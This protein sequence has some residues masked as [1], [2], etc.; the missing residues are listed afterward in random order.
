MRKPR[1]FP[2]VLA[3]AGVT[4]GLAVFSA[5]GAQAPL[6]EVDL[7]QA[8]RLALDND[9]ATVGAAAAVSSASADLLEARGLWLPSLTMSSGYSNSS[10]QRVDTATGRLVSE[11]YNAQISASLELFSGGRRIVE[12]RAAAANLKA[13]GADY[14]LQTFQT[15]L[16]TTEIFYDAAAS[17]DLQRLAE[18]RRDR[19]RQQLSFA[20]TRFDLGTATSS[21]MLRAQLEVDN[22]ELGVLNA[23][24]MLRTAALALG[25]QIGR[26][27]EI[28][29]VSSSLPGQAPVLP[30]TESLI[31]QA[32]RSSPSVVA[33]EATLR[34]RQAER[35]AGIADYLP[36]ATLS[37]GYDWFAFNFPPDQRSWNLRLTASLPIFDRFGREANVQRAAA[38][39]RFAE[40]EARDAVMAVRVAVES[41]TGEIAS[42]ARGIEIANHAR[43][44]ALEDLRVLEER[45]QIGVATILEL[46]TSQV[47]LTEAEVAV[48]RARQALGMAVARLEVVLGERIE[49]RTRE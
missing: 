6:Q 46:Q 16:R 5:A 4:A 9:P 29:P 31:E 8:I 38:R 22:A 3:I 40:A 37:G 13:A 2:A 27:G 21:D 44:L 39:E 7:E 14:R 15:I 47:A 28:H 19:A 36:S 33:A 43:E 12:N 34:G 48:V 30:P 24:L 35:L 20:E 49:V 25:R 23:E 11:S 17:A 41:A 26:A 1:F 18:Q 10:D 42:V 32:V 45:Y